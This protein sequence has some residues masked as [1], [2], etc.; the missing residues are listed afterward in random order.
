MYRLLTR[1]SILLANR[2]LSNHLCRTRM[3][4]QPEGAKSYL[5]LV[6]AIRKLHL[7][8]GFLA[9]YKGESGDSSLLS[10]FF[11]VSSII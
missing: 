6:D 8:G 11:I 4:A 10:A 1:F 7:E 2:R 3:V 9:F 5:S